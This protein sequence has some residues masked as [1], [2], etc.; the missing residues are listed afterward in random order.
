MLKADEIKT[1][2]R[3]IKAIL[4]SNPETRDSDKKL[5]LETWERQGLHLSSEQKQAF[6]RCLPAETVTRARRA[7]QAYDVRCMPRKVIQQQ[8]MFASENVRQNI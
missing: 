5:L 3:F 4:L 2:E 7:I 6:M 1:A 8:R